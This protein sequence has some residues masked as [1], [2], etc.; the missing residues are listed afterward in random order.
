MS[1]RLMRAFLPE[2]STAR[3]PFLPDDDGST[4]GDGQGGGGAPAGGTGDQPKDGDK[5]DEKDWK[6]EAEKHKALARKHEDRAKANAD[7]AA[8]LAELER[9]SM[10]EAERA[11]AEARDAGK[12]EAAQQFG[13]QLVATAAGT[14][15]E[16]RG[17]DPQR[18][19]R[20]VARIA[21]ADFVGADGVLNR[22]ALREFIDDVA[23]A[24]NGQG[25]GLQQDQH[26]GR[27]GRQGQQWPDLG[28]GRGQ[29]SPPAPSVSAG[30]DLYKKL[31]G[32]PE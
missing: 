8:K 32:P 25:G 11:I 28:Q 3:N 1:Q 12:A 18:A 6:A 29:G 23:P 5:P 15:L 27:N 24:G 26:G 10:G 19:E 21:V 17:V 16:A 4:G 13:Q 30:R 31:L 2:H 9:K 22:D 20:L 7:A 14:L